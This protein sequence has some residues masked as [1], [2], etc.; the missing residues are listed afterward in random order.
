MNH[1]SPILLGLIAL[2]AGFL[3]ANG[4]QHIVVSSFE[5]SG[6]AL[7]ITDPGALP[8]EKV[9]LILLTG[10]AM[11]LAVLLQQ[12]AEYL[13]GHCIWPLWG[14]LLAL[15]IAE[16]L[17]MGLRLV[18]L[19]T[20]TLPAAIELAGTST[21]IIDLA[22]TNLIGWAAA[23]LASGGVLSLGLLVAMGW[24]EE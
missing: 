3:L 14:I 1:K 13:T 24:M 9:G 11:L 12:T 18:T 5:S 7:I 16:N 23:G 21:P 20:V 15:V 19:A 2:G 10:T 6:A 22:E 17:G 8:A 4:W